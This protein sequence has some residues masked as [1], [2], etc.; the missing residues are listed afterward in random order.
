M[1]KLFEKRKTQLKLF[2]TNSFFKLIEDYRIRDDF[3]D[4]YKE[5]VK[6]I[7][8]SR[9]L[10]S[11]ISGDRGF[12]FKKAYF[13][14]QRAKKVD[15]HKIVIKKIHR[16]IDTVDLIDWIYSK[17][18]H[19][20]VFLILISFFSTVLMMILNFL[21]SFPFLVLFLFLFILK[22]LLTVYE[23]IL[24]F[25]T[26]LHQMVNNRLIYNFKDLSKSKKKKLDL[27]TA[28]IWNNSLI[29]EK[30]IIVLFLMALLKIL[31]KPIYNRTL[32]GLKMAIPEQ[33]PDYFKTKDPRVF[34]H[35]LWK[36]YSKRF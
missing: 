33:L 31:I 21:S 34:R 9:E 23:K 5:C 24:K 32:N 30:T 6:Y 20:L 18:N 17:L 8:Q 19:G 2:L 1:K 27:V 15:S 28:S 26:E 7:D 22:I 16:L 4:V 12:W 3:F 14:G 25:D 35:N 29:S 10:K 11:R 13:N 36:K